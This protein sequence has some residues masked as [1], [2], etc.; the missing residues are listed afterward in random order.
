[1]KLGKRREAEEAGGGGGGGGEKETSSEINDRHNR[2]L[3]KHQS[4]L[5]R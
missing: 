1:M 4:S 2:T 5:D 3:I